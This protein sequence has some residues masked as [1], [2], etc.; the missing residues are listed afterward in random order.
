MPLPHGASPNA[1]SLSVSR[2]SHARRRLLSRRYSQPRRP[3]AGGCASLLLP[4]RIPMPYAVAVGST[5]LSTQHQSSTATTASCL[6][7][8]QCAVATV[9]LHDLDVLRVNPVC[10]LFFSMIRC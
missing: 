6:S 1:A 3:L 8:N 2:A 5:I 10:M 7:S 9:L 4:P